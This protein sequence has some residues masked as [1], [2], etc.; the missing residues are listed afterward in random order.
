[1]RL[2]IRKP[3]PARVS[4]LF[5]CGI[6]AIAPA[7]HAALT[8]EIQVY[9]DSINKPGERGLELHLNTTPSG[10]AAPDYA[11]EI[12]P[13]HGLRVTPEFSWGLTETLEAGLY[14]PALMDRDNRFYVA[15]AK[16]RLKWIPKRAPEA[17]FFWGGN[18]ELSHVGQRFEASRN[19][20]ELRPIFGYRNPD[21]LFVTNP[22]LGY[23]L[24]P[25]YR[26]GG[27][28]FSPAFKVSRTVAQGLAVGIETYS[29]LGKLADM[30]PRSEQQHTLYA[31]IDVDR[32]PW[33]FNFGV[34]RGL[35]PAT[36]RWT[37]KAI[38]EIP[39]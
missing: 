11:G 5:L 7:A 13:A 15:G 16:L 24:S 34:G 33:V 39:Y 9:D 10:R 18:V 28:D 8:D 2:K 3:H 38:F 36:D 37:V 1:M 14:L 6:F 12:P 25:G 4:C 21:W 19:G 31:T 23:D 22:V 26:K 27:L 29:E 30:S 17:G 32:A 20:V 35:N